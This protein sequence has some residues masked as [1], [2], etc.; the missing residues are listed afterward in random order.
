MVFNKKE[1]QRTYMRKLKST[2]EG[3]AKIYKWRKDYWKENPDKYEEHK[4]RARKNSNKETK[5]D[6]LRRKYI[7]DIEDLTNVFNNELDMIQMLKDLT[8]DN[9]KLKDLIGEVDQDE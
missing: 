1:Y 8:R 3:R 9:I 4:S 7:N 5:R 2:P 6:Q